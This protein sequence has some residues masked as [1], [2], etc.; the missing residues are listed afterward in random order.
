[1]KDNKLISMV[2]F[3]LKQWEQLDNVPK[4]PETVDCILRMVRYAQFLKKPLTLGMFVPCDL[5]GNVLEEPTPKMWEHY[6]SYLMN[7]V[8]F[9]ADNY[10]V[11]QVEKWKQAKERVLFKDV[12]DECFDVNNL[13]RSFEIF[14]SIHPR[15]ESFVNMDITLTPNALKNI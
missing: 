6:N 10:I 15:V 11:S 14:T 5:E 9:T 4:Q 1:M 8:D 2:D 7:L 12:A 3:V 13:Q